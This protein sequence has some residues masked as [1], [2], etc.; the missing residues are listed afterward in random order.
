M[1]WNN[2]DYSLTDDL[3]RLD[4]DAVC[5][6]LQSTYWAAE[7]KRA[8]TEKCIRHSLNFSLFHEG[9][10]IGFARVVTDYATF[11]YLCDVVIA[12]G[13][14]RKG[15]GKWMLQCI[16]EHREL[17]TTR[18]SLYTKDAQEFYRQFGFQPHKY[19]CLVR[20][21]KDYADVRASAKA[22]GGKERQAGTEGSASERVSE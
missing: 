4:L 9:R 5:A 2:G 15:I 6:L 14:R 13:H 11:S 10:Q 3:S 12:P 20:Y 21:P 19:E 8:T 17:V 22:E 7:R 18:M 16:L 1:N